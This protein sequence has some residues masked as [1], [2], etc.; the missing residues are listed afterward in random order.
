MVW[1]NI[2]VYLNPGH[3]DLETR[4]MLSW[5]TLEIHCFQRETFSTKGHTKKVKLQ[6][7]STGQRTGFFCWSVELFREVVM[8]SGLDGGGL[9]GVVNW[10]PWRN[11]EV[12]GTGTRC[13]VSKESHFRVVTIYVSGFSEQTR[14]KIKDSVGCKWLEEPWWLPVY[15]EGFVEEYSCLKDIFHY[16]DICEPDVWQAVYQSVSIE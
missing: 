2:N 3:L 9:G 13:Y 1:V 12:I 5:L 15:I 10:E 11:R 8:A 14:D 16:G 4:L 6:G 7:S